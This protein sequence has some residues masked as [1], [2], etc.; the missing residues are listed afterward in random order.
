MSAPLRLKLLLA[1]DGRP[2]RG[3]QSQATK[4][5]VQDFV[6]AA[7]AKIVGARVIVIGSGRTDAGVH[8]LGQIAHAEVPRGG[9][10][11]GQWRDALNAN[12]P[13]EIRVLRVAQAHRD[14]HAQFDARGK[15][16]VYRIWNGPFLHPLEIGRAWFVPGALDLAR[17][18]ECARLLEGTHDFASFAANRGHLLTTGHGGTD[19]GSRGAI[20]SPVRSAA[21]VAAR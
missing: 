5:A 16:Y 15:E 1:Y 18:R 12:L 21:L 2:F 3:W 13:H 10:P 19:R 17:L 20:R 14:F 9:M 8:A 11:A 6:E 4:D 7:F